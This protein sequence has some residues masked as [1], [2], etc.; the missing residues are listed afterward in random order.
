MPIEPSTNTQDTNTQTHPSCE[1]C[2]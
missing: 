2:H 1:N